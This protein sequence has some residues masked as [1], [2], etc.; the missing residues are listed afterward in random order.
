MSG[1]W[2][3]VWEPF[4][5]F[6]V[7]LDKTLTPPPNKKPRVTQKAFFTLADVNVR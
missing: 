2:L 5:I 4:R 6:H 1:F 7:C 3:K